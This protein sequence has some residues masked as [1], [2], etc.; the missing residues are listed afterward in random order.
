LNNLKPLTTDILNLSH[1]Y[2]FSFHDLVPQIHVAV[3]V[4]GSLD[5]IEETIV[6]VKSIILFAHQE[7]KVHLFTED[8]LKSTIIER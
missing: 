4:C 1:W 2:V 5:R 8:N 7:V 3:V 6:N